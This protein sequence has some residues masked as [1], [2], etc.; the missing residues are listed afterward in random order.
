MRIRSIKP[1][2]WR[3]QDIS[4]LKDWNVRFI[5]IGLWSYVDDNG[6]G[7]DRVSLI[8]AD[9]FAD[10]LE[11]DPRE[12]FAR[13]SEALA[14][15]SEAG[16]IVRYTV[17]GTDYLEIVN[18]SKHQRIDKP[19]KERYPAS[20][21]G[22]AVIRESVATSS[23]DIRETP[24]PG[25]EEQGNR[26]T[27]D[28]TDLPDPDGSSE[29][30]IDR[31][32]EADFPNTFTALYPDAFEQWWEYYPR[33]AG[34]RKAFGAWKSARKR[35]TAEELIEGARRYA[36]DP[37]REDKYTKYPEG[38]LNRDGWLDE[39]LPARHNGGSYINGEPLQGADLRAAE[40]AK[41]AKL[42]TNPQKAL[43][44]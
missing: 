14:T 13:V 31:I 4:C 20:T 27:E 32:T 9:L 38:W 6:V 24:A 16:R 3:S 12:T 42:F 17:D 44:Q 26:G 33:K 40:N 43:D 41:I 19:N 30:A 7:K 29:T 35:A 25:T 28:I 36:E 39:P 23:R 37:N 22:D 21:S 18:W 2:F 34:K 11:R 5:F 8:A 10:D 1:D 15:L